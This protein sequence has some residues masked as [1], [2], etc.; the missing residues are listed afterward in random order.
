MQRG[1][2][3]RLGFTT[4]NTP[5]DVRP[6]VL[7]RALEDRGYDSLWIGEHSHIPASRRTPYPTGGVMPNAYRT[8]MDPFVSLTIAATA[9]TDLIV[10]TGVALALEHDVFDLAKTVAT[11]DLLSNG[12]VKFGVGCGWN[13]EELANHRPDVTWARRYIALEECVA[14]LRALWTAD[15]SAHHGE[16]FNFD[17][18]WSYPKPMQR[19][20]PPVV[21]GMSGRMGTKHAV[22]WADEWNPMDIAL[23]N[24]PKK[25]GLFRA[26]AAEAG[27]GHIPITITTFGDP[28]LETLELYR[29]LGVERVAIG[30]SREGWDD[31]ATTMPFMDR[32]A[33]YIPGLL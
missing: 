28:T 11:L 8:M 23:G 26:A 31:P 30:A 25:I 3:V 4:M 20:H 18:V 2:F 10:A 17:A 27:R 13:E 15:E 29:S 21:C 6:D 19:P 24:V 22:A 7:A 16:Y 32:Y 33:A 9:T 14:A 12:R 5:D 1:D